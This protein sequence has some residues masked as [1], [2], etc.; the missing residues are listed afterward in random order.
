MKKLISLLL[1]MLMLCGVCG[2]QA[3]AD[4][5]AELPGVSPLI[6][7]DAGE[8]ENAAELLALMASMGMS[9]TLTIEEDGSA[10]ID[11]FGETMN[12]KFDFE[13]QTAATEGDPIP[14]T[15][16]GDTITFSSNGMSMVFSKSGA[17]Q[18]RKA[19]GAFDCYEMTALV[20]ADGEDAG[21]QLAIM[22]ELGTPATML[23]FESGCAELDLSGETVSMLFDF[24]TMTVT[25]EE[26]GEV[27]PFTLEDG[28]LTV[29]EEGGVFMSFELA[30]PGWSGDY[31][32]VSLASAEG[33]MTEQL[34]MLKAMGMAPTLSID[35]NGDGVLNA[36]G[37]EVKMHFDFETMLVSSEDEEGEFP[38]SYE[39]G[40]LSME[41]EGAQM[42]FS[43]AIP[44]ENAV[45]LIDM[46]SDAG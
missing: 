25:E 31:E 28:V 40:K 17:L 45:N 46:F 11:L 20:N 33:D 42:V 44:D 38:F 10:V 39:L 15:F 36:F 32:V 2:L 7:M 24:E 18:E 9:P 13:T 35:E 3:F 14:Y 21:A 1:V 22:R 4:D 41:N 23:L 16:D 29:G 43:R 19:R 5:A 37:V 27:F 34:S 6:D 26:S 8:T 12:L 30:D